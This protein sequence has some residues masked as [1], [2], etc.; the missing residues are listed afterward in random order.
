M[1]PTLQLNGSVAVNDDACLEQQA[2]LMG[3]S[4]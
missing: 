3:A 4:P 1:Q 2:D